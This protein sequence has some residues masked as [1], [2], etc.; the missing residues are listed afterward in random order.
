MSNYTKTTNFAAKDALAP[1][2]PNGIIT[3]TAHDTEFNNIATAIAT[4]ADLISPVLVTPNIGAATGTSLVLSGAITGTGGT[5]TSP[6]LVTPALGTPASGVATNLT[7]TATALNIGGNAATATTA[8][9]VTIS[10]AAADTTTWPMLATS[11]TGNLGPATDAGLTYNASTNQLSTDKFN[12]LTTLQLNS[13]LLASSTAPTL[14]G[15]GTSPSIDGYN[16]TMALIISIGSGAA[17]AGSINLPTAPNGW[18]CQAEVG[19]AAS[20]PTDLITFQTGYTT[21]SVSMAGFNPTTGAAKSWG[22][23]GTKL[24]VFCIPF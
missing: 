18:I 17:A 16:G 12:A 4:K 11:Q 20:P 10:D 21:T 19:E 1:T 14:T 13:I 7:G 23:A 22:V 3:G 5:L 9:T 24:I 8:T 2:D 6:T 15:F